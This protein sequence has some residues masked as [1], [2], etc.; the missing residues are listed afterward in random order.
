MLPVCAAAESLLVLLL[1]Q[2][3]V[4]PLKGTE[5][6]RG[7]ANATHAHTSAHIHTH[8]PS[9]LL[10]Q[11]LF[12]LGGVKE[13]DEHIHTRTATHKAL[14]PVARTRRRCWSCRH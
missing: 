3:H 8:C 1:L 2:L 5:A 11:A 9:A 12:P 7:R 14:I 4:F 10:Q 13:T 6:K